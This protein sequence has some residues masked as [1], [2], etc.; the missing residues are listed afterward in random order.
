MLKMKHQCSE[1]EYEATTNYEVTNP[2]TV[3]KAL[4]VPLHQHVVRDEVP[5]HGDQPGDG[6]VLGDIDSHSAQ[7]KDCQF[8]TNTTSPHRPAMGMSRGTS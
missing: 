7:C 6:A 3:F 2:Q 8:F 5:E 4:D 1:C